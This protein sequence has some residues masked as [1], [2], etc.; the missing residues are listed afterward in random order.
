ANSNGN[1]NGFNLPD[2]NLSFNQHIR[3]IFLQDC[4]A[5]GNCH[6]STAQAGGLDLENNPPNFNSNYGLVVINFNKEQS[7]LYLLLFSSREGRSRM[8][9]DQAPLAEEKI[10]A[11]GTWIDEGANTAN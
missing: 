6:G 11:I 10:E 7:L 2:S 8:P 4:A 3:P 1:D 5:I 9:P